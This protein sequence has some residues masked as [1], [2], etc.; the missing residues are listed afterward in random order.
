MK[1]N[2]L[3]DRTKHFKIELIPFFYKVG[4]SFVKFHDRFKNDFQL[5]LRLF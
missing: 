4:Y 3:Y 2:K 5:S 1:E